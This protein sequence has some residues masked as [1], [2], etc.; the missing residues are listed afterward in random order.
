M[1]AG[2]RKRFMGRAI[3]VN[4]FT[5][6]GYR[7]SPGVSAKAAAIGACARDVG[8]GNSPETIRER[9]QCFVTNKNKTNAGQPNRK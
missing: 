7:L 9:K 4:L 6:H 5:K 3:V 8:K 1:T 2:L